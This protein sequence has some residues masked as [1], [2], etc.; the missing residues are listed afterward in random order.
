MEHLS[1]L[2]RFL[3]QQGEEGESQG[4]G[5]FTLAREMSLKK[6]AEFQLPFADAWLL[7]V[8]QAAVAEQTEQPI[9]IELGSREIKFYFQVRDLS[10]GEIEEAFFEPEYQGKRSLRHLI[11]ALWAAG[12]RNGW[13]FQVLLPESSMTLVWDGEK[14]HRKVSEQKFDCALLAVCHSKPEGGAI[15]WIKAK[16]EESRRNLQFTETLAR[17]CYACPV[18]LSVDGHRIDSLLNCPTHGWGP[19]TLPIWIGNAKIEA[20]SFVVPPGTFL[21]VAAHR[22]SKELFRRESVNGYWETKLAQEAFPKIPRF[23]VGSAVY[24][25]SAKLELVT[26]TR[27]K[28]WRVWPEFPHVYWVSDGVVVQTERLG[29][30]RLTDFSTAVFIS[31]ED[32]GTDLTG[33]ALNDTKEKKSRMKASLA[34]VAAELQPS[35]FPVILKLCEKYEKRFL[36]KYALSALGVAAVGV[37]IGFAVPPLGGILILTGLGTSLFRAFVCQASDKSYRKRLEEHQKSLRK[38]L[39]ENC[40]GSKPRLTLVSERIPE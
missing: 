9:R 39:D 29:T 23:E 14:L 12:I 10:L 35:R 30:S 20:P 31:A 2:E 27:K 6:L 17:N 24:L 19:K 36:R 21:G 1:E 15:N 13:S 8:V 18:P 26:E 5:H 38:L 32:L 11:S 28:E 33:L 40:F 34:A 4:E 7:K 3:L 25:L 22:P 37:P 16:V